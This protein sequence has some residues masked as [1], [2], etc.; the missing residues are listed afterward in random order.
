MTIAQ[1]RE[2]DESRGMEVPKRA[3]KSRRLTIPGG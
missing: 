1:L 3:S 2:L